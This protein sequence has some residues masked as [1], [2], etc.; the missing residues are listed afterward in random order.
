MKKALVITSIVL[1][2]AVVLLFT[3]G[4][5]APPENAVRA[6]ITGNVVNTGS[7][8]ES[9]VEGDIVPINTEES[10]FEFEGYGPGK[11][12]IG[13]FEEFSGNLL[14]EDG[15]ITG[16]EGT[17]QADSV[18]TGISGLDSHLKNEDFFHVEMYP[19]IKFSTTNIDLEA[20]QATGPLTFLGVTKEITFP[21]EISEEGISTDFILDTTPFGMQHTGTDKEVRIA[22]EF[23]R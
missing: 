5:T 14:Y 7:L 11:S 16:V 6:G 22:F 8:A 12:H 1:V 4:M 10:M 15:Q 9:E 13:V 3:V 2:T 19:E 23:S 18:N 17:I 21:V 20:G